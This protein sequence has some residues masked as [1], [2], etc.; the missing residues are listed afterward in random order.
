MSSRQLGL[1][2]ATAAAKAGISPLSKGKTLGAL[3][4]KTLEE[5]VAA[6][7][8]KL[9]YYLVPIEPLDELLEK[10]AQEVA[11]QMI[12]ESSH[13]MDLEAQ[14]ISERERLLQIKELARELLVKRRKELW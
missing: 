5:T 14:P 2:Q 11:T 3:Q 4:L 12:E 13:S 9:V 7:N 8:C 6:L 10:R 1:P